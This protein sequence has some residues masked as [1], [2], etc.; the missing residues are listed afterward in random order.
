MVPCH[1]IPVAKICNGYLYKLMVPCHRI[2][3]AKI[4]NGYLYK[5][6][7]PCHRISLA[8]I[9]KGH[10]Y[11]LMVPCHRISLAKNLQ[12]LPIHINGSLSQ[13]TSSQNLQ[14][15]PIHINGS[16][17]CFS[18]IVTQADCI[19]LQQ[20]V[21][22]HCYEVL[23]CTNQHRILLQT[24]DVCKNIYF[25]ALHLKQVVILIHTRHT[26]PKTHSYLSIFLC[27]M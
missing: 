27:S 16:L 18:Q 23:Y 1:R 11:K 20:F 24:N 14:R 6:M 15:L 26:T 4:C 8:K 7:V 3:L 25:P 2:S 19:F 9:C 5:L 10:L 22:Q 21:F 17:S 13:D 12:R